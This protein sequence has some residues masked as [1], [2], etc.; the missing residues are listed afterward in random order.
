MKV[1]LTR[2]L[3][4]PEDAPQ[5]DQTSNDDAE[6]VPASSRAAQS[7]KGKPCKPRG[8]VGANGSRAGADTGKNASEADAI[9]AGVPG[10]PGVLHSLRH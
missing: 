3:L 8:E 1:F 9:L 7:V 10:D 4:V 6:I 2:T 5:S